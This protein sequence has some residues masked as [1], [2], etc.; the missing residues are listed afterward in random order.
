MCWIVGYTGFRRAKKVLLDGLQALE[1][2]GYDSAG[3]ALADGKLKIYKCGGRVA[4]LS[5]I[6]P[7]SKAHT[8]IGH[9]RW[10]THGA[11]CAENAHPHLSFDGKIAIV[12]NG[13]IENH[14]ELRAELTDRGIPL[15]SQTDSELIAHMLAL[16]EGDMRERLFKVAARTEGAM[17]VLAVCENDSRIYAYRRGA[18]LVVAEGNGE[19]FA[20]SDMLALAPYVGRVTVLKDGEC[21]VLSPDGIS[22]FTADGGRDDHP[23][24]LP[25]SV[26][27]VK[28]SEC[29]MRD[30]IE[31]IPDALLAH[32]VP[33]NAASATGKK[34]YLALSI[35]KT[36]CSRAAGRRITPVCTAAKCWNGSRAYP[37]AR[38]PRARRK[39]RRLR[40][41]TLSAS[42]SPRAAKPRIPC[43]Q[44]KCAGKR[45]HIP[46]P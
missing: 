42:S 15:A 20:S 33:S 2:R 9:T 37:A 22:V 44:W 10:A 17:T 43:A 35:P 38:F 5:S 3:V 14:D 21:A 29:H 23:E 32:S 46:L 31:E 8:G 40:T 1:Y 6:I 12:H 34:S 24:S 41:A 25:L 36:F 39:T 4:T 30:E 18:A 28:K 16:E 11:P 13:V 19:S 27:I 26:R 45:A 7:R